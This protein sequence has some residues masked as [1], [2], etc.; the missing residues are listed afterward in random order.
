M[1]WALSRVALAVSLK[2]NK[3]IQDV[4]SSLETTKLQQAVFF[5]PW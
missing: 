4:S 2:A 5:S 3:R 1:S